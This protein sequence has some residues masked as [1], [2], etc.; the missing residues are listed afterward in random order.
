M[1]SVV[2][3]VIVLQ[4]LQDCKKFVQIGEEKWSLLEMIC[5][6][7]QGSTLG[8]LLFLIYI[9][10]IANLSNKLSFRLFVDDASIFYISD[11]IN[12]IESVM[13]YE[14]TKVLN[15]SSINKLSVNMKKTNFMLITSPLKNVTHKHF[16]FWAKDLHEVPWCLYRPTLEFFTH[17]KSEVSKNIGILYKSRHYVSIH[18]LKQL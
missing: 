1:V 12:D 7:P 13:N 10:D 4:V 8:P 16:K 6:V 3:R 18:V 9:D 17:V 14:M 5:G 11:D 2:S 15:N